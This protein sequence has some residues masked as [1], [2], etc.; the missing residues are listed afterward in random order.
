[1]RVLPVNFFG[2]LDKSLTEADLKPRIWMQKFYKVS[3]T[4]RKQ[5]EI[6]QTKGKSQVRVQFQGKSQSQPQCSESSRGALYNSYI[7]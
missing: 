6:G 3:V 1:M 2:V 5:W 4:R 7:L